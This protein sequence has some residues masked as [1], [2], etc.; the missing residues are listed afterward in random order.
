MLPGRVLLGTE[1]IKAQFRFGVLVRPFH[2]VALALRVGQLLK[3]G[4][5]RGIAQGVTEMA[6]LFSANDQPLGIDAVGQLGP[7]P[8]EEVV[9]GQGATFG[10]T[11]R[12]PAVHRVRQ[13]W[14]LFHRHRVV[15]RQRPL[16]LRWLQK[17]LGVRGHIGHV[18]NLG[19]NQG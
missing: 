10:E 15:R 16:P 8:P 18:A 6:I 4:L 7:D 1:V 12:Y 13:L 2:E 3:G 19:L 5:R 11:D 14:D 17:D 9:V